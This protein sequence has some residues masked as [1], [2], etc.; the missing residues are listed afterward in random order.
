MDADNRD[1]LFAYLDESRDRL[2]VTSDKV[3]SKEDPLLRDKLRSSAQLLSSRSRLVLRYSSVD[4]ERAPLLDGVSDA[5]A[6]IICDERNHT[7]ALVG[8][9]HRALVTSFNLL[10]FGGHSSKRAAAFEIGIEMRANGLGPGLFQGLFAP[11]Y[12]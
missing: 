10:S 2:V 6:T 1:C 9:N 5:G 12:R 3:T 7:K 11:L 4:G 8:D